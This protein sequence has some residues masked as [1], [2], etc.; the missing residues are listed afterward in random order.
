MARGVETLHLDVAKLEAVAI[1]WRGCHTLAFLTAVYGQLA[2]LRKLPSVS[3]S[4]FRR[5]GRGGTSTDH[6]F[7]TSCMVPVAAKQ[8][9]NQQPTSTTKQ[10]AG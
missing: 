3:I 1:G 10:G 8:S 2:E 4:S 9:Q 7:V 6:L 5:G